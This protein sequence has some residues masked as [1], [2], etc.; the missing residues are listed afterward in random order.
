MKTGGTEH[1]GT[2]S[3][4]LLIIH[5]DSEDVEHTD[6]KSLFIAQG[7]THSIS[8]K[9]KRPNNDE[10][11]DIADERR[12]SIFARQRRRNNVPEDE[13]E[14]SMMA[15]MEEAIT[16][17]NKASKKQ[18]NP[19]GSNSRKDKSAKSEK[20]KSK[21]P[22]A[23]GKGTRETSKC[24][25]KGN[26]SSD[27]QMQ[28]RKEKKRGRKM[29]NFESMLSNNVYTSANSNVGVAALPIV[30]EKNKTEALKALLASVPIEDRKAISGE[31]QHIIDATRTL[32][33]YKVRSDGKG[34][35]KLNGTEFAKSFKG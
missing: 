24:T 17:G 32:G 11:Y 12:E 35:W 27:T 3:I 10:D 30:T 25:R 19:R 7:S 13:L 14:A 8:Q 26:P 23:T 28:T 18:S 4:S 33:K 5:S 20:S 34:G 6:P 22:K 2:N 16:K 1:R 9:R 15:G 31:K 29:M 21:K